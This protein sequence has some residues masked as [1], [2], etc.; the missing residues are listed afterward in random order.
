MYSID[1]SRKT[2]LDQPLRLKMNKAP[3]LAFIYS[4]L[5]KKLPERHRPPR[6]ANPEEGTYERVETQHLQGAHS[7]GSVDKER[8][9]RNQLPEPE[10]RREDFRNI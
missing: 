4:H 1:L 9:E 6:R 7:T 10:R 5:G 2:A 3:H 8:R